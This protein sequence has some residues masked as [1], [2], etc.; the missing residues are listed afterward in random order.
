[1]VMTHQSSTRDIYDKLP[2]CIYGS[3][4]LDSI[5][6]NYDNLQAFVKE[7]A[8]MVAITKI[9]FLELTFVVSR[10][11]CLRGNTVCRSRLSRKQN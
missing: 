8:W 9:N 10:Y 4:L 3:M 5:G 6:T 11:L 2:N 1:M 7:V